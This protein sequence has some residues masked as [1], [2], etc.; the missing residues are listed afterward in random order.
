MNFIDKVVTFFN[1]KAGLERAR[2]RMAINT[3]RS[4]DAARPRRADGN[5]SATSGSAITDIQ[6]ALAALRRRSRDMIR[7]NAH[8][9][10]IVDII[11]ANDIGHGI[12][13]RSM[14]GRSRLDKLRMQVWAEWAETTKCDY[15]GQLDFYGLQSLIRRT[16]AES[17]ECLVYLRRTRPTDDMKI[18]LQLQVLE[19]DF[20][21]DSKDEIL[22]DGSRRV[23]GIEFD[24]QMKRVAYWVFPNHPNDYRI[25]YAPSVRVSSKDIIHIYNKTRPGQ[26]RGVPELHSVM[27]TLDDLRDHNEAWLLRSK[28]EACLGVFVERANEGAITTLGPSST[29]NGNRIET[30]SP[31]MIS[32][33]DPGETVSTLNPTASGGHSEYTRQSLMA[34]AAGSNVTYDQISTDM[35]Q[36]NYSSL[37][38]GK[39]EF[40]R[41]VEQ[42]QWHMLIP[43]LCT[44]V[45]QE[46]CKAGFL[47][48]LWSS[49]AYTA[50]WVPPRFEAVD[51]IKDTNALIMQ[52]RSGLV[53]LPEAIQSQG[54]DP[55]AQME[56][57][58]EFNKLMDDLQIIVDSDPRKVTKTGA[59]NG[60]EAQSNGE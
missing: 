50:T 31:G 46:F 51:P 59:S 41:M 4:Y 20:L 19:P 1:P 8:A 7:N 53:T 49:D 40:R 10:R 36:A 48:G 29:D 33:L 12:R 6:P 17:G 11:V 39:L 47:S 3:V 27:Q 58:S 15:E 57:I 9:K 24:A 21:D 23:G 35:S 28:I 44:P 22:P 14:M 5:W 18:P 38:A 55:I 52:V 37:R 26:H 60:L 43:M 32:Y 16:I 56:Q 13:P 54:Y 34:A 30:I 45:W 25:T 42:R 2:S